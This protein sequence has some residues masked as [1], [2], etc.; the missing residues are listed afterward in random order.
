MTSHL[1][2]KPESVRY[3]A[4][5]HI[6]L[7]MN[8]FLIVLAIPPSEANPSTDS[9]AASSRSYRVRVP[10]ME[11]GTDE[12]ALN[13]AAAREV[14]RE[15]DA[16][17]FDPPPPPPPLAVPLEIPAPRSP[18]APA[19]NRSASPPEQLNPPTIASSFG[20]NGGGNSPYR[21]PMDSPQRSPKESPY[22]PML[23][24]GQL[25]NMSVNKGSSTS[26]ASPMPPSTRTISAAAFKRP[27]PRMPSMDSGNSN[28]NTAIA[29]ISPLSFKKRPSVGAPRTASREPTS[30]SP[31]AA[32]AGPPSS[33]AGPVPSSPV[34]GVHR[35]VPSSVPQNTFADEDDQFD[36]ITAYVNNAGGS[37]EGPPPPP[38]ARSASGGYGQGRF[39][40]VLNEGSLR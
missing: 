33:F 34:D 14:S 30:L 23:T 38:P 18:I 6:T 13:A 10:S 19:S 9:L 35:R 25:S 15:M 8:D 12:N 24:T 5:R 11:G 4:C 39:A 21:T 1:E 31:R 16:L 36:Y 7:L 27:A 26:L 28:S 2:K 20:S 29:D 37:D 40:T 22:R 3:L 32:N 17:T